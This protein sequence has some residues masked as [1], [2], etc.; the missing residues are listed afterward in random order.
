M[1]TQTETKTNPKFKLGAKV[2]RKFL[3]LEEGETIYIKVKTPV[4]DFNTR[5]QN[6]DGSPKLMTYILAD[7]LETNEKD[8]TFW[9]SGQI[10][11]ILANTP[12]VVGKKYAITK[13]GKIYVGDNEVN[14]FEVREII[15]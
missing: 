2:E 1:N 8:L 11:S 14:D 4:T 5:A 6:E 9:V 13:L 15:D 3:K 7:N 12:S 10:R